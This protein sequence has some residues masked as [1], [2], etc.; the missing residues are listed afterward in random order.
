MRPIDFVG[1]IHGHATALRE[2]VHQLGYRLQSG[3][4]Q[5]PDDARLVFLGDL[6]DRGPEQ[7]ETV[8][9]VHGLC[10]QGRAICLM[11]NHEFNAVG[12]VTP[13]TDDPTRHVRSHTDAHIRQHQAFLDAYAHHPQDYQDTIAWFSRLPLWFE[14]QGVR[15][16]HACWHA[17]A[18]ALLE[19]Y[20]DAHHAPIDQSFF[21]DSAIEN[22]PAWHGRETLL[23][24]LEMRLPE[25]SHFRDYYG[26]QRRRIRVNWW[27]PDQSTYRE[28]AVIDASQRDRIPNL[29][30]PSTAPSYHE[31]LVFFGHYWMRGAPR[32]QHPRAVCLDYSIALP[33]GALCAYR[34]QGESDAQ[35]S[36]LSWVT[37]T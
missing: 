21:T 20:V 11:G 19:P 33:D 9:L 23:N 8:E 3:S 30:L 7:R 35:V 18:Q 4:W 2:L 25:G 31:Q 6:I 32:I 13:R 1:D 22:S 16:V 26:I 28:S 15:A 34:Y 24:G 12:F 17:P 10:E 29:P 36:H 14:Q 5:H 37:H 27:D